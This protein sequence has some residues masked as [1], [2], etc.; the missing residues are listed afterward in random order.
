[1]H[2]H[3]P[4]LY[5]QI[6]RGDR[7]AN[8][9]ASEIRQTLRD[10]ELAAAAPPLPEGPFELVYADPPWRLPGSPT[11]SRA[12]ENHYPTMPLEEIKAIKIPAAEN[13]LLFLWGVNS[14]TPEA[15]EVMS[16]WGFS[17]LTNFAWC[18]DRRGLGQYNRCQ[19]E[20]LHLGRRGEFAP[21]PTKRRQSSVIEARRGRHSEKPASV[22][23]LIEAMYPHASK[24][25]LF[26][27]GTPR[28][29]WAAWGNEAECGEVAT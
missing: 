14:M 8:T 26:A 23:E 5:E 20:L 24:L 13:S 7:K 22:Y 11:S 1:V 18:K 15:L 17:Y 25:E 16:A 29:G 28:P 9:A 10:A 27:R 3:D 4:E 2:E 6:L 21:P 19:H 12:V